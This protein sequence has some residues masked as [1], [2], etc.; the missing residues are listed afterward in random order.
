MTSHS[1]APWLVTVMI[2]VASCLGVFGLGVMIELGWWLRPVAI[3]IAVAVVA[4]ISTRLATASRALPSLVGAIA[5]VLTMVPLFAATDEGTRHWWPSPAALRELG[6][7]LRGGVDYAIGTVAPAPPDSGLA[8]LIAASA[9]ALFLA[10]EH[11]AVSW[12]AAATAGLLLLIPWLPAVFLQHRVPVPALIV[13]IGLWLATLSLTRRTTAAERRPGVGGAITATAATLAGVLLVA[14]T[15]LGGAGWGMIPRFETPG[16]IDGA[17]RLNLAL[18]LRTS[19]TAN[20]TSPVMVYST[21]GQR[22]DAF[23]LYSLTD[24]DGVRWSRESTETPTLSANDG[25]LWTT[26]VDD[27]SDRERS[28]IDMRVLN[29]RES[30]LPLPPTPRSLEVEGRWYYDAERDEVVGDGETADDLQYSIVT[31]SSFHQREALEQVQ[32]QIAAGA[33]PADPRYLTISPAID[34]T[35]VHTLATEVTDG[36]TTRYAQAT[37]LQSYLRD[38]SRF[39]YDTSVD[40]TG[41]DAISTFLDDREGY[42]VQFATTMVVMARALDIPARMAVGFLPGTATEQGTYV[43]QGGDAHAW[44]EL[45]FPGEGWVRFEPTPAIQSGMPPAYADPYAGDPGSRGQVSPGEI[46]DFVPGEQVQPESVVPNQGAQSPGGAGSS[47]QANWGVWAGAGAAVLLLIAAGLWWWRIG[48][49][50]RDRHG[51]G[52]EAEWERLRESLPPALR[53]GQTLTP[54]ESAEHVESAMRG[55]GTELSSPTAEGLLRLSHA[56]ADARYAPGGSDQ[57]PVQLREWADAVA[58]EARTAAQ[59]RGSRRIQVK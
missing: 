47:G 52:P 45:W 49:D 34:A 54:H 51:T 9:V 21:S 35:R 25:P 14:P 58:V 7:T 42:C 11:L 39:T 16:A 29:L 6:A 53:W 56:V 36:A 59:E 28:R 13:A 12:R 37:A 17:T 20:S 4:I 19:L 43:V 31:D 15:A 46:P 55:E 32:D 41:G 50:R 1:R 38:A 33:A 10:A 2:A 24:F 5:A 48:R 3:V 23:R 30:N 44:P 27:W 40:P 8:A 18:D 22:P 57:D 26:P